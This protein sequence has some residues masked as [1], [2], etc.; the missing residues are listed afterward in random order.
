MTAATPTTSVQG[1]RLR[2]AA[3]AAL[4][5]YGVVGVVHLL[6]QLGE[7]TSLADVTQWLAVPCLL[8]A[9]T[10]QTRLRSRLTRFTA[11]GLAWSWVGDTLPDLVP[12]P[13]AFVVL[14]LSF[15][16]AHVVFA[17]GFWPWH[18]G[19]LLHTRA[20]WAY[21]AVAAAMVI[22]C[23]PG[24]GALTVGIAVYAAALAL[25]AMLAAGI[26]R[27]ALV[28]GILFIASD[29]LLALR[30]FVP[31]VEVPH[32]GFWVMASYLSALVLITL[33]VLRRDASRT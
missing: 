2:P 15:L 5:A 12:E 10:V 1:L 28:G 17:V 19:S 32:G 6:G 27:W 18:R 16:A 7:D 22:V 29:G 23:A 20:A 30:E 25:M 3:A 33:G 21:A 9:L 26:D 13:V 8:L 11:G 4:A 31:A 14:M 24:A